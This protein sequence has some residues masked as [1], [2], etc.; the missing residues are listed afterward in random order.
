[1]PRRTVRK[2][3]SEGEPTVTDKKPDPTSDAARTDPKVADRE[4]EELRKKAEQGLKDASGDLPED[5]I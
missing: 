2:Q 1:M 3:I 5:Q 4:R